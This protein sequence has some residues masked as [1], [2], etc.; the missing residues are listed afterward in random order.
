MLGT[1]KPPI[2]RLLPRFVF[3]CCF[4][5]GVHSMMLS[6]TLE[7]LLFSSLYIIASFFKLKPNEWGF[8]DRSSTLELLR[9]VQSTHLDNNNELPLLRYFLLVS[10]FLRTWS[11]STIEKQI[12]DL[13]V[14]VFDK[15][16]K[17]HMEVDDDAITRRFL[18]GEEWRWKIKT[19]K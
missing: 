11:A 15:N 16:P 13:T 10:V 4:T 9:D 5:F 3:V 19:N 12:V 17:Q 14:H 6:S 1:V 2:V 8:T 18:A 7:K